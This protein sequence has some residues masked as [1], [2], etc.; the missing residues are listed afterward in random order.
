MDSKLID[1]QTA[2]DVRNV[3]KEMKEKYGEN[4]KVG[5][6]GFCWGGCFTVLLLGM[7]YDSIHDNHHTVII[8][9]S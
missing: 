5:A 6:Q 7:T 2:D 9:T 3:V 4:L 8:K 1:L